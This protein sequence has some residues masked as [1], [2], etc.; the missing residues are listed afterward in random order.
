[1]KRSQGFTVIEII[2][3]ILFL[4]V[5]TT[6]LFVQKANLSATQRDDQRKT[7]V[8]AMY[9]NLEEVF[10]EKNGYYPSKIDGKVLRAMDPALFTDPK[11]AAMDAQ[12]SNYHYEG[13][14]CTNDNCKAYRLS[15]DMEK[16]A[17]Y[18]KTNRNKS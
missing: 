10:F 3:A 17:S 12:G 11:G 15:A 5:A 6:I 2:V 13:L 1:M 9:Y 18:V 7:A 4:G 14:N 8:N 16:E